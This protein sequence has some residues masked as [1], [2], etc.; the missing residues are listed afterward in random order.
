MK[1]QNSRDK[2][3]AFAKC[4]PRQN[5]KYGLRAAVKMVLVQLIILCVC[6]TQLSLIHQN[7]VHIIWWKIPFPAD[8]LAIYS[9]MT[10]NERERERE[11]AQVKSMLMLIYSAHV[12]R[13]E[14][15]K[16]TELVGTS[17]MPSL[18]F[19][20]AAAAAAAAAAV[21]TMKIDW[22]YRLLIHMDWKWSCLN[23]KSTF[24]YRWNHMTLLRFNRTIFGATWKTCV[25]ALIF[26]LIHSFTQSLFLPLHPST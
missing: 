14:E 8:L 3:L 17:L 18:Q 2:M 10:E 23:S 19:Y 26:S 22:H 20:T 11:T 16:I 4:I 21:A 5:N 1:T 9:G 25:H 12:R 13:R 24:T 15:K 6:E 7:V